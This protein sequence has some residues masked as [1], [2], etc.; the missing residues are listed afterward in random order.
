MTAQEIKDLISEE[1]KSESNLKDV[2]GLDLTECLIEPARQKYRSISDSGATQELWTVLD[3]GA[4][5]YKIYFDEQTGQFGLGSSSSKGGL[6]DT[7][8]RGTFLKTLYS[9]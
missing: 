2:Y 3:E 1:L 4:D 9:M 5:G 8:T 6:I 7:G